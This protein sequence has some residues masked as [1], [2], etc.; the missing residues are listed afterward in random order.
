MKYVNERYFGM[1]VTDDH[2]LCIQ[3][4][5]NILEESKDFVIHKYKISSLG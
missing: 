3:T 2:S 5:I 4:T 1:L